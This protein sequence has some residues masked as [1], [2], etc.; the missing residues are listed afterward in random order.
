MEDTPKIQPVPKTHPTCNAVSPVTSEKSG[1]QLPDLEPS[2]EFWN[3]VQLPSSCYKSVVYRQD[4][5]TVNSVNALK[6]KRHDVDVH[7]IP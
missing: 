3:R 6:A 5:C 1:Y 4:G 2:N 7:C